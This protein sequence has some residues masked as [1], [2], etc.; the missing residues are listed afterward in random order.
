MID[1]AFTMTNPGIG[2]GVH[3]AE[4]LHDL[5]VRPG[6][7][8]GLAGHALGE[9]WNIW[10]SFVGVLGWLDVALPQFCLPDR[11]RRRRPG[12]GRMLH[13]AP[14]HPV[15]P[16]AGACCS[17]CSR[18]PSW[19]ST[20]SNT[21]P[22]PR[23]TPRAS[24]VSRGATSSRLALFLPAAMPALGSFPPRLMAAINVCILSAPALL[25]AVAIRSAVFRY[26][27]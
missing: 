24:T 1:A 5:L 22:T 20:S 9:G 16:D 3:P 23:C 10:M 14:R 7:W 6:E 12:P 4:Q 15:A 27:I 2:R 8:P 18:R 13:A 25:I 11:R 26:Y 19:V 21:R 17:P